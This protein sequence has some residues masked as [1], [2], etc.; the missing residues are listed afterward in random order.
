MTFLHWGIS[1]QCSITKPLPEK[2]SGIKCI[3][4]A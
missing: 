2:Q 4:Q 3:H 1:L